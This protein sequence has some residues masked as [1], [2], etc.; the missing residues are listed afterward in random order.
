MLGY[1]FHRQKPLDRFIVDFYCSALKL[2]I[3]I[4]G[5]SHN[6]SFAEDMER[7]RKLESFGIHFLRFTDLEVK[8]DIPNVLRAI[9]NWIL[10]QQ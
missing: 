1:D 3:E 5:D 9:E 4:D 8:Q 7:Q 2:A 10:E 6:Y